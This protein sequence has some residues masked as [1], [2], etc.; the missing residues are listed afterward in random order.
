M[1]LYKTGNLLTVEAEALVNPVNCVGVMGKGIALQF[2]NA[3]PMNFHAYLTACESGQIKPGHMNV[4][5]TRATSNPQ[6]IVNFPTKR[7][8]R[9]SSRIGDIEA[10]LSDLVRVIA[11][12]QINSIAMPALG[13][14]LGG[15][16]WHEVRSLIER[17]FEIFTDKSIIVFEPQTKD[18]AD[19]QKNESNSSK[20]QK[21]R[22]TRKR[23]P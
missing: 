11:E 16:D 2:K 22:A 14:G 20:P 8:W 3:Y 23:C 5:E 12:K 9:D 19:P 18:E 10:G 13:C 4:F 1:I 6:Y 17:A 15:L 21:A 7:H